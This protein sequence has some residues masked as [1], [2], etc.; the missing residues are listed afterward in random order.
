MVSDYLIEVD[1]AGIAQGDMFGVLLA[2]IVPNMPPTGPAVTPF[3]VMDPPI[4]QERHELR[5]HPA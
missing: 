5:L 4:F 3:R 2:S 1:L